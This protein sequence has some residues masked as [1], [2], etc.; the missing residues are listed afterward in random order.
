MRRFVFV[1]LVVA[2]L[3]S[4]TRRCRP[5]ARWVGRCPVPSSGRSI[6]R[7]AAS[8]PVTSAST[9]QP[10]PA[11]RC[12]PP[13]G[14]RV[15]RRHGRGARHRRD[16]ARGQPAHV[17]LCSSRRSRC[18]GGR[19]CVPA[20]SSARPAARAT[21][22]T[23]PCCTSASRSGDTVPRPD[24][25]VRSTRSHRDRAPRAD[26]R[27]AASR[28]RGG[29]SDVRSSTVSM[30]GARAV[31]HVGR[32]ALEAGWPCARHRL[33]GSKRRSRAACAIGSR[34]VAA[35]TRTRRRPTAT[36][37]SSHRVMVVAGI[38]SSM[39]AGAPPLSLPGR[40]TLGYQP[41]EVT[42]FSYAPN[43]RP[44]P[45]GRHR[46]ARSWRPPVASAAQLRALQRRE[47]GREVDLIGTPQGG[48]VV[49]AFL[50]QLYGPGDRSY[51]A[52]RHGRRPCRRRFAG[53]ALAAR[54]GRTSTARASGA[55]SAA[56]PICRS[57]GT[58]AVASS[59]PDSALTHRLEGAAARRRRAD[60]DRFR[61]RPCRA[62]DRAATRRGAPHPRSPAART[63]RT[64]G[65]S[66][67]TRPLQGACGRR[68]AAGRCRVCRWS[69]VSSSALLPRGRLTAPRSTSEP[70]APSPGG[71]PTSVRDSR[72]LPERPRIGPDPPVGPRGRPLD[73]EPYPVTDSTKH[74]RNLRWRP[75][76]KSA[77][78]SRGRK[79][80][81]LG[82]TAVA[83][84][85]MKQLL[86]AGVHFG[87]QTRRWNPKMR[88]FIFGERNGI[89]IIDLQQTL[90]RI[91]TAYRFVREHRR[92]RRH[93]SCSS[94]PRSRR[95]SRSQTQASACGMPYVNYRWLGGMLT[96]FQTVH[97]AS[98]SCASC[99]RLRRL[100]RGR[101][102]CRR[103]KA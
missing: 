29:G 23:A 77:G 13:V 84:V 103:R 27:A 45:A 63:Q 8:A 87:H 102:R 60:H 50:T 37:G 38:E 43:R 3:A 22:T 68:S 14:S 67:P 5:G 16:R 70:A 86:E 76:A 48:V 33:P 15:V 65:A 54:G 30:R 36:G 69:R 93:A 7:R 1:C 97:C 58:P 46:G 99:E 95:R 21:A 47:P 9:S 19:R 31:V 44:L 24:D 55:D 35:A 32:A 25:A 74:V 51:S 20:R 17:L 26:L 39:T 12:W 40:A 2:L 92:R 71:S 101:R 81:P 49:E 98:R 78:C 57:H 79:I 85:S 6:R 88:R 94:A 56:P 28:E 62:G 72:E 41:D 83:V 34:S 4:R 91:D 52:A 73:W 80:E 75:T 96:N 61:H 64:Q 18:G 59:T 66:S 11:R 42:Y 10:R 90:E 82:G 89:Y 53:A 100:R